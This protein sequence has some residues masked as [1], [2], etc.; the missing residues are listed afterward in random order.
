MNS[1]PDDPQQV[2]T[3]LSTLAARVAV[4]ERWVRRS[5]R[6][7]TLLLVLVLITLIICVV[8]LTTR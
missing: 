5:Q 1:R 4:L 8:L 7:Q 2:T 3:A 6:S